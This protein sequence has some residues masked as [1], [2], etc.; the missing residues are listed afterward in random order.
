MT[1]W[2]HG[3]GYKPPLTAS[4]I[5][6]D[7]M[8]IKWLSTFICCGWAF[9]GTLTLLYLC[10]SWPNFGKLGKGWAKMTLWCHGWG[11]EPPLTAS[12][13]YIGC[14]E[15]VWATSYAVDGHM[16]A[17]LHCYTFA[18]GS[19]ILGNWGKVKPKWHCCACHGWGYKPPLT[20]SRIHIECV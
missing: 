7:W 11:C 2:C 9:G 10:R 19:W 6:I 14:I 5:H 15:S 3:W 16:G 20:A 12:H 17:P 4:H 13:I 8:C 18:G 1:L